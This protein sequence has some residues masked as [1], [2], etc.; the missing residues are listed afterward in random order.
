MLQM[1][2]MDQLWR[3]ALQADSKDVSMTATQFLNNYYIN[4]GGGL[5]DRE[6]MFVSCCMS[7][8]MATLNKVKEVSTLTRSNSNSNNKIIESCNIAL[9]CKH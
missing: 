4:H 1:C 8:L 2:G 6:D 7:S 9:R 3:I 5:L